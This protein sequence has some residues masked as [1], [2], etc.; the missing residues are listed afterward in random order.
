MLTMNHTV[1]P[2]NHT[3]IHKWNEP[4]LSLLPSHRAPPHFGQYS[5]PILLSV[6]G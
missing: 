4:Y 6:E 3:F 1:L 2:A 5:F